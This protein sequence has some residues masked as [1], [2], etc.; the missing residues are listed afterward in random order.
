MRDSLF[1]AGVSGFLGGVVCRSF[2]LFPVPVLWV[3]LLTA[4]IFLGA[5]LVVRR[6]Q[7]LAAVLFLICAVVGSAR[8]MYV[9]TTL[10]PS[11]TPL[12]NTAV[13]FEGVVVADPDVRETTMRVTIEVSNDGDTTKVLAVAPLYPSVR[14]GDHVRVSGTLVLPEPFTT[15]MGRTFRYDT[16][17]AKDGVFGLVEQATL[18]TT[19]VREGVFTRVLGALIDMK[20]LFLSGI[21]RALPEPHAALAGGLV[22]GGKQGLGTTLLDAFV[23]S[24]LIHIVVLSGYNVMIIA[25]AVL[26]GLSFLPKRIAATIAASTIGAFVLAAGAGAASIRAGLMA[27]LALLARATGRTYAVLRALVV[28]AVLMV[29]WN[30]LLLVHDPGFQLSFIA[31]LGLILGA[32]LIEERLS[33][34][35]NAFIRDVTASTLAAQIAVLPL[36]LYQTGLLSLVAFPANIIVLP[37]VPFAMAASALAGVVGM[38]VPPLAPIMGLPAYVLL[39]FIITSVEYAATLPLAAL[40][41][42]AFPFFVTVLVYGILGAWIVRIY[43]KRGATN[44]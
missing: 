42:P 36:L 41:I 37:V 21:S 29:L 30:P 12:V 35:R 34:I 5:W 24:G 31:T 43:R 38:V 40:T 6:S 15:D 27:G 2:L 1:I 20:H 13:S 14:Y 3:V 8:V 17:L 32:P 33:I 22:A 25:E 10:P 7:Y 44:V 16:F 28:V 39:S 18:E 11:F 4:G 19:G 9:P 23:V 26:R